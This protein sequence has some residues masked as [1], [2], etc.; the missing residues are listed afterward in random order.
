MVDRPNEERR[1]VVVVTGAG[2]MGVAVARR[3]GNGRNV[4]LADASSQGL[5]RAVTALTDE[6]YA[7][8]GMVTDVSDRGAVHKLAEA[9]AAEGRVAAVVHTAGVSPATGPAKTIVDVNL[10]GTAHVIDA[11]ETVA[12]RGTALVVISSMAGHVASLSR[13][14][15][16]ALATTATEDLL[17]L[18]VVTAIGDDA[19]TAYIVTK[20]ANHLRVQAAALAWNL[21]GARVNS[22]SPGVIATA[23]SRAEAASPSGA[24]MMQMLDASG[25]GRV[26][27]PGEIADAVAFLT[28]PESSYIT[29]T[30]LLVDGG[31]AAWLRLHFRP[32]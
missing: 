12:T 24:H 20:R 23:M 18:D 32:Q 3:L 13:E 21:R 7:V 4:L 17:G 25:S 10:L 22:V 2:G 26:G 31:Q 27:T 29:G 15:E 28:S 1:D 11:F 5:D 14:E 6:G 8:R 9:S 30:D 19:Q 16:A